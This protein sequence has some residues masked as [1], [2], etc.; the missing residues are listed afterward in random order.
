VQDRGVQ[1][2]YRSRKT[3]VPN[4]FSWR[5][6]NVPSRPQGIFSNN[7]LPF[8]DT[9]SEYYF[10]NQNGDGRIAIPTRKGQI[11]KMRIVAQG[12]A[13]A[14]PAAGITGVG[15]MYM[16]IYP[17]TNFLPAF[18]DIARRDYPVNITVATTTPSP[19]P[20]YSIPFTYDEEYYFEVPSMVEELG[21]TDL[22][23]FQRLT[24]TEKNRFG[25]GV[26]GQILTNSP[27]ISDFGC[28]FQKLE[29]EISVLQNYVE[30]SNSER[31]IS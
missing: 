17:Q 31:L 29:T 3:W 21:V 4:D 26:R 19:G 23:G 16:E 11:V 10:L 13:T 9:T 25:V 27:W 24:P 15:G 7:D 5:P 1:Q 12:F 14:E 18:G 28:Y 30:F 2:I 20:T 8:L 6:P 22:P